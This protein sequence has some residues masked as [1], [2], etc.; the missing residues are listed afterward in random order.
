MTELLALHGIVEAAPDVVAAV[1]LDVRPGG[2]SPLATEGPIEPATDTGDE[3]VVVRDGSRLTVRVDRAA[4]SVTRE[5]EWWY[6]GVTSV[7]PDP[8]GSLVIARILNIARG[9]R[10]AVRWVARGPLNAAPAGFAADLDHLGR[11]LG[12][13][14]WALDGPAS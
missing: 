9:N 7:Q 10:W 13:P 8:R 3:F 1:L 6:R 5:G 12:V 4:R 2:R 11:E 14:A